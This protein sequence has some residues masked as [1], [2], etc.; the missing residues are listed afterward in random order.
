MNGRKDLVETAFELVPDA[1]TSCVAE[2]GGGREGNSFPPGPPIGNGFG[3]PVP[4]E[5]TRPGVETKGRPQEVATYGGW[6]TG[7]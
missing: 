2:A 5:A 4:R 6:R 3:S 1:G 7:D